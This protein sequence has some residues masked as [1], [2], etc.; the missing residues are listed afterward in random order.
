M[1]GAWLSA[2]PKG[3][4][5]AT[6]GWR[7]LCPGSRRWSWAVLCGPTRSEGRG[8]AQCWR[9]TPSP[10]RTTGSGVQ[11]APPPCTLPQT[12][13]GAE[14]CL[15]CHTPMEGHTS[16][17]HTTAFYQGWCGE[18]QVREAGGEEREAANTRFLS[19]SYFTQ[20]AWADLRPPRA[21]FNWEAN[22]WCW[23]R[24]LPR[25][26]RYREAQRR[27]GHTIV[28]NSYPVNRERRGT[29]TTRAIPSRTAATCSSN[30]WSLKENIHCAF[31]ADHVLLIPS[32]ITWRSKAC[33]L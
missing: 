7:S 1:R 27:G 9:R 24:G 2:V 26:G 4:A 17:Q 23:F 21:R 33:A 3:H 31:H 20:K 11:R 28:S 29:G 18:G 6:P 22:W 32:L 16:H 8:S 12:L 25:E 10:P 30:S 14:G 13:K 19:V 5:G 15:G